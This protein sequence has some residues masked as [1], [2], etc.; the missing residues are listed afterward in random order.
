MPTPL[1]PCRWCGSDQFIEAE[2]LEWEVRE[3]G[4][5]SGRLVSGCMVACARC[6]LVES[7]ADDPRLLL[8]LPGAR[9]VQVPSAE[10]EGTADTSISES[11]A[12]SGWQVVMLDAGP[13]PIGVIAALRQELPISFAN[14]RAA[15]KRLPWVLTR[16]S[17]RRMADEISEKL[18]VMGAVVRVEPSA[19]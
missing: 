5:A 3:A 6:G 14:A 10:R 16:T 12:G 4:G 13:Q 2:R 18:T 7:F 19:V 9:E 17:N 15:V 11:P 1:R 8:E